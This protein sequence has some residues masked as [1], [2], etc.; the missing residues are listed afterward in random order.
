L[1]LSSGKIWELYAELK[2]YKKLPGEEKKEDKRVNPQ[3]FGT[4]LQG[5][6]YQSE[7]NLP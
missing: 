7:K 6:V 2:A 1:A 3:Q 4:P 5:Y